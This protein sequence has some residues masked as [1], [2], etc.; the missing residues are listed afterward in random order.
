[1]AEFDKIAVFVRPLRPIGIIERPNM[2]ITKVR[3]EETS[4]ILYRNNF[5]QNAQVN[6]WDLNYNSFLG[7]RIGPP[8]VEIRL[9][10]ITI[11]IAFHFRQHLQLSDCRDFAQ[12]LVPLLPPDVPII[13]SRE[14]HVWP[15]PN[16]RVN[17]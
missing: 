5:N 15:N 12:H 17:G 16:P 1:M 3:L 4:M 13:N 14:P 8:E 2:Y 11:F 9:S 6:F 7:L 10:Q